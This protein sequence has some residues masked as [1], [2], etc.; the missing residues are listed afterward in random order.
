MDKMHYTIKTWSEAETI[1]FAQAIAQEVALSDI[2]LLYGDLGM[3]KTVFS[4]AFIRSLCGDEDMEV[5]SPTF[6]LVQNYDT[7]KGVVWHFDFYRLCDFEEVYEIGWEEALSGAIVLVEWPERLGDVVP[8]GA[9]RIYLSSVADAPEAR[10]IEVYR[11]EK[12]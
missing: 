10:L 7:S 3:G 1:E 5:P 8:E 11:G 2:L 9:W 4:R 12:G 6:T